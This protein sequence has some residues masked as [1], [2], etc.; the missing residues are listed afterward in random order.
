MAWSKVLA[1]ALSNGVGLLD[2]AVMAR[3]A[4]PPG[5]FNK[6]LDQFERDLKSGVDVAETLLAPH[7][8]DHHGSVAAARPGQ[9]S[10][11]LA[12]MFT[13]VADGYDSILRDR[14]KALSAFV[15][16][17]DHHGRRRHG[18]RPGDRRD[19]GADVRL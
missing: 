2:A 13:F 11:A 3:Q 10:G 18:R 5:E 6:N 17:F 4:A 1:F 12:R 15:Q 8:A 14:M 9:K 16:P 7:P 19:D